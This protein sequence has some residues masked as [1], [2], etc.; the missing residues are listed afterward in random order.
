MGDLYLALSLVLVL[1]AVCWHLGAAVGGRFS[2]RATLSIST[3]AAGAF[4]LYAVNLFGQLSLARLLP[5]A[6]VIVLGNWLPLGAAF[7]AG[8]IGRQRA[9]AVWRRAVLTAL[10]LGGGAYSACYQLWPD[11]PSA[12]DQWSLQVL[13]RQ[14]TEA[15]C[16]PCAAATL[17][18]LH[19]IPATEREMIDL[20]LTDSKGTRDLGLYRGLKLKTRHTPWDIEPFRGSLADLRKPGNTPTLLLVRLEPDADVGSRYHERSGWVPGVGHAVVLLGTTE[21]GRAIIGDPAV[22][23]E[24]WSAA[25]LKNLWRGHALRLVARDGTTARRNPQAP[26]PWALRLARAGR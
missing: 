9:V 21:D 8:L 17:L 15:S 18:R 3:L 26:T 4:V 22:G 16:S 11:P 13:C 10:L 7:F 14:T 2:R 23:L 6:S 25:D 19:G 5:C 1:C 24:Y 20:C 12:G